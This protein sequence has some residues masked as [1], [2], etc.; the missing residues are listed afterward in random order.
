MVEVNEKKN[1]SHYLKLVKWM[2]EKFLQSALSTSVAA[3]AL[4]V[5]AALVMGMP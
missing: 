4:L 3:I 2:P 5:A 1:I